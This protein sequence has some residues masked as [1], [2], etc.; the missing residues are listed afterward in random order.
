[1]SAVVKQSHQLWDGRER[2]PFIKTLSPNQRVLAHRASVDLVSHLFE[3]NRPDRNVVDRHVP[4][5][6]LARDGHRRPSGRDWKRGRQARMLTHER[7]ACG[8]WNR[9]EPAR[10]GGRTTRRNR[11]R[12]STTRHRRTARPRGRRL[13]RKRPGGLRLGTLNL[14][15][16]VRRTRRNGHLGIAFVPVDQDLVIALATWKTNYATPNL[17]V[18]DLVLGVAAIALESHRSHRLC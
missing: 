8:C 9:R 4:S 16:P 3:S 17:L 6:H 10:H 13:M 15:D 1:M 7:A 5:R 12:T 2:P 14:L 18:G 11:R